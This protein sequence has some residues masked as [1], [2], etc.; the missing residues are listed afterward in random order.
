VTVYGTGLGAPVSKVATGQAA[1]EVANPMA[2]PIQVWLGN[3]PL[4]PAYAGLAPDFVGLSQI[5]F[6]VP[7][8]LSSGVYPLRIASGSATSLPQNLT[9]GV[10]AQTSG[11]SNALHGGIVAASLHTNSGLS[12]VYAGRP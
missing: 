3:I 8:G 12:A 4:Q 6:A 7:D 9:V 5:N 2:A 10:P 1:P 11:N